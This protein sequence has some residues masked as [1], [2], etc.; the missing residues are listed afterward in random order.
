[1]DQKTWLLDVS[2]DVEIPAVAALSTRSDGFG[3]AFGFGARLDGREPVFLNDHTRT[4]AR[5]QADAE[6]RVFLSI[7]I[8][9]EVGRA[10]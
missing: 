1:M 8:G 10:L 4:G 9:M 7:S 3:F 5:A 6:F 2:T